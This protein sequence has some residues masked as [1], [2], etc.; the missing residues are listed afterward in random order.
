MNQKKSPNRL[1]ES[2]S[3]YL[4][5]HAHNPVDWYPWGREAFEKARAE[6]K[7]MIISIGYSSCH[8]CHV[9]ERESF[10]NAEIAALMNQYFVAVK[11]DREERP[12]V[13]QI[14]M[15]AVQ[16]M[17]LQGGW[18]L[19][20]FTMPDQK[21]FY[22]GTY[23]PPAAWKRILLN[24]NQ[25]YREKKAELENSAKEF[26]RSLK[27]SDSEKYGLGDSALVRDEEMLPRMVHQM[28][29][30]FDEQNGGLGNAPKFPNPVIWQYLLHSNYYLGDEQ[31]DA[32]IKRTLDHMASG[33]IYDH[34]GGGFARYSVDEQWFAP[35]FEKMLYDNAQLI[36]LYSQAFQRYKSEL[37]KEVVYDTIAFIDR[38]M[39]SDEGAF[40][41][42]LDADSEGVEGKYYTWTYEELER[43]LGEETNFFAD[44]Y[45]ASAGGNWEHGRNILY[46]SSG[47]KS[48]SDVDAP[49]TKDAI[50]A[51]RLKL[52]EAR[53]ERIRPGLDDKAIT[54]W[55]AL[56]IKGLTDAYHAFGV[57]GFLEMAQKNANFI[58]EKLRDGA[59]LQRIYKNGSSNHS[60]TLEDYACVIQALIGLYQADFDRKWLNEA[61]ALTRYLLS[62][63]HDPDDELFFFTDKN[64]E[65]LLARKKEIFDNVIPASNSIIARNLYQLSILLENDTYR[66]K[67]DQMLTRIFKLLKTE[68]RYLANWALLYVEGMKS[69]VEIAIVGNDLKR[70]SLELS[71]EFLPNK[72]LAGTVDHDDLP[73]LR[74][75][76]TESG[77]TTIYVCFDKTC[78]L[79][80]MKVH[81]ALVQIRQHWE[82]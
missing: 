8:W 29:Q 40:Y 52:L 3:P 79:P 2:A 11:V 33:G 82:T 43:I 77:K 37:Y 41:S 17:G 81:E 72:I 10:E 23:F 56:M 38:E 66:A 53:D 74:E 1:I 61:D 58:L 46:R 34:I 68:S 44:Y 45:G 4:L 69:T 75:R 7:P 59:Q 22:G 16:T 39:T 55:N 19:N 21:P 27:M 35:H 49:T 26:A 54:G 76:G 73:L 18:P 20:V 50:K 5:Q 14:Y 36:S 70:F 6:D 28:K 31:V 60:G 13:D 30:Y 63:F 32:Q 65:K 57:P 71:K 64:A 47:E 15:E 80:V 24:V 12:D 48:Q 51:M 62:N 67:A 78:K 25:A 42:A 9:M